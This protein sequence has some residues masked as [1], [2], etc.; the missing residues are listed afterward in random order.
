MYLPSL[1]TWMTSI[2]FRSVSSKSRNSAQYITYASVN[3][4]VIKWILKETK[5]LHFLK[6]QHSNS[7]D[8]LI[9]L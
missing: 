3:S 5:A 8:H 4:Y 1:V 9:G 6:I 7:T 2:L